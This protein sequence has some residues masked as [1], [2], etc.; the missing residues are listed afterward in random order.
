[1]ALLD[2]PVESINTETVDSF[3]RFILSH[4]TQIEVRSFYILLFLSEYECQRQTGNRITDSSY[5]IVLDGCVSTEIQAYISELD[6]VTKDSIPTIQ[7]PMSVYV[8]GLEYNSGL[9]LEAEEIIQGLINK[10]GSKN[11]DEFSQLFLQMVPRKFAVG[12]TIN[13]QEVIETKNKK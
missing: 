8:S 2:D 5:T 3:V 10:Y 4:Y 9:P 11:P 6:S 12:Q 7:G 1:M 13:F